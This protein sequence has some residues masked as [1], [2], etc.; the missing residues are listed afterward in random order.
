MRLDL[1]PVLDLENAELRAALQR[2]IDQ[3]T[4][5]LGSLGALEHLA[6]EIGMIRKSARPVLEQ[7]QMVVFAGDHGLVKRGVS[8][9]P[10]DVTWQMVENFLAGGAAVSVLA[11]QHGIALTVVDCGVAHDFAPREALRVCKVAPG[12]ADCSQGPA[13]TMEQC[14]Q[15]IRN[16]QE[17]VRGLP[18]NALML[19]EMGIGNGAGTGLNSEGVQRKIAVLREALAAN[20]D[21]GDA[22]D[23]LAAL[24]GFEIATM[25]GAM[26]QADAEDRVL[27]IDGVIVT[28]ALLVAAN[29][30]PR[31][32][33]RCIYSHRSGEP[34]HQYML[35]ALKARPLLD[36]GMRLGEGSGAAIAWPL[37]ESACTM[38]RDMASFASAGVDGQAV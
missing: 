11:K 33:Q 23:A 22:L 15:A 12:T 17:L 14:L 28:S 13:M 38:L 32:L 5:P 26:L 21:T 9:F 24:G 2:A 7:P 29:I 10:Q 18:G 4:K 19:G 3:K 30:E 31:V 25:V 35:E 37:L 8:A 20:P 6:L 16:G 1:D 27:L 36:W 34:G